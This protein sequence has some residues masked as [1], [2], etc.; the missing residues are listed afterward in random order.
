MPFSPNSA[1]CEKNYPQNINYI[2]VVIFFDRLLRNVIYPIS[3]LKNKF[4]PRNTTG[5]SAV[6]L[7]FR[8]ELEEI[9]IP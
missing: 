1:L 2:P 3:A 8:L 7:I 5:M 6:K 9:F 4:N